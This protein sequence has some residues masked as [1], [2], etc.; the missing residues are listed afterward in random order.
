MY[1]GCR[2]R[3]HLRRGGILGGGENVLGSSQLG[4][5]DIDQRIDCLAHF[6]G[7]AL[8]DCG[9][10]LGA[11]ADAVHLA[12]HVDHH[13][14]LRCLLHERLSLHLSLGLQHLGR[15]A[16]ALGLSDCL[17]RILGDGLG[18]QVAGGLRWKGGGHAGKVF[19]KRIEGAQ[20]QKQG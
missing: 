8:G 15:V 7:E 18:D 20:Q 5:V 2:P 19:R 16:H 10:A 9:N 1:Q 13:W 3:P 12:L 17:V 14:P 4:A 6:R 11:L